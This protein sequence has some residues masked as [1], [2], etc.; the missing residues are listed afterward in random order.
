MGRLQKGG[1]SMELWQLKQRQSLPLE[2]KIEM[3]KIRIRKWYE[4]WDGDVYVSFSGGKDSTV[5]LHLV[6]Y[7]YPE[8]PAVFVDT[9]L[10]YPEIRDFVKSVDNVNWLKPDISFRKVI[11]KYGYPVISKDVSNCIRGARRG[12]KH[13]IKRLTVKTGSK[14]DKLKWNFLLKSKF[15]ISEQC[16]DVMKKKPLK[17]YEKHTKRYMFTGEMADDS[18]LRETQYINNGCN[19]FDLDRPKSTPLGFWTEKDIWNY[20]KLFN[21]KYSKIYDMGE[22]RTG[23]IFCMFGVH[24]EKQ[25]NRFQ[26]MQTT[27]PQLYN[28]C[29]KDWDKGGLGIAK[30][31][32]YI[33]VPYKDYI[34]QLKDYEQMVI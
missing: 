16:C 4:A 1:V 18:M 12:S 28:Y 19:A 27:H 22:S 11:E 20:I 14:Y 29:M 13:R 21:V 30:V 6:R 25:P 2:V 10:E 34:P 33:N 15:K 8:V 23:C 26:R 9:G 24:F 31:L 3:S 17:Q 7:M 5:L 32:E